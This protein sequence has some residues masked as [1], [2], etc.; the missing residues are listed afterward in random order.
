CVRLLQLGLG[1]VRV[2]PGQAEVY[3]GYLCKGEPQC[4]SDT[5]ELIVRRLTPAFGHSSAE[6][7]R[8][9]ARLL[10]MLRAEDGRLLPAIAAQWS[11]E[12]SVEDDIHYLI[13]ASLIGGKRAAGFTTAAADCLLR[14][15][16]KLDAR[17]QFASRNWPLRVGEVFD[18]LRER[19]PALE[20]AIVN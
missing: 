1:D 14:L 8:E 3:T 2:Q 18:E 20:R 13:A 17:G 7:N 6:V 12:S 5:R 16:K 10:G 19:D 9:L 15:H 11:P 4:D